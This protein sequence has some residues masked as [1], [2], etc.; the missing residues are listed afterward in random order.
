[1]R[2]VDAPD[3]IKFTGDTVIDAVEIP[4]ET[5]RK[6]LH[7]VHNGAERLSRVPVSPIRGK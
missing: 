2:I 5:G 7:R 3:A 4:S 1:M 6:M